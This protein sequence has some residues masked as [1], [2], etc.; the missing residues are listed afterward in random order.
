MKGIEELQKKK[1][2]KTETRSSNYR[3]E[4]SYL[5]EFNSKIYKIP[6][7]YIR[8]LC[9]YKLYKQDKKEELVLSGKTCPPP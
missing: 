3:A 6:L 1:K 5:N 2:N 8:T 4:G 9:C 7:F